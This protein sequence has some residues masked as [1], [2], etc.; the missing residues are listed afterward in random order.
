P[1]LH[2]ICLPVNI[3]MAAGI[4]S[5]YLILM[6]LIVALVYTAF[7]QRI[8]NRWIVSGVLILPLLAIAQQSLRG[9]DM[10]EIAGSAGAEYRDYLALLE[11]FQFRDF[12]HGATIIPA[13][14]NAIPK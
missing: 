12:Q 10:Y 1:R 8:R 9:N 5:R 7:T 4:G 3:V 13:A 14:T 11:E 2:L 6:P